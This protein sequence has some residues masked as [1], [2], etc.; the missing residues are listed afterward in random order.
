MEDAEDRGDEDLYARLDSNYSTA[1]EEDSD[2]SLFQSLLVFA[3]CNV[4]LNLM[5]FGTS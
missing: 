1:D 3:F 4:Q 2:V 5:I